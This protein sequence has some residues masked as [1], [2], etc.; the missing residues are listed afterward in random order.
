MMSPGLGAAR[1][2]WMQRCDDPAPHNGSGHAG[3]VADRPGRDL[4]EAM[5]RDAVDPGKIR[6]EPRRHPREDSRADLTRPPQV[7]RQ[8]GM[9]TEHPRSRLSERADQPRLT[10]TPWYYGAPRADFV[11]VR[12][13]G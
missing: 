12:L 1:Q 11:A 8:P 13:S 6:R 5:L 4:G 2:S 3:F 7:L 10:K 9:M